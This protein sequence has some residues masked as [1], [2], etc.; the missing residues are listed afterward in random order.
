MTVA[1]L[2]DRIAAAY[3]GATP[4]AMATFKPVF[5]ARL[6][7]HEGP[8]LA[9]AANAV[10][11]AFKPTVRQ[12]FPIP[13]D[14]E[15]QLPARR[16]KMPGGPA[17]RLD[18]PA[19]NDRMRELLTQWRRRQGD[20]AS[21]GVPE[22]MR[23]L[24]HIASLH[25]SF[26]SWSDNPAAIV[27][28]V[29]ELMQARHRAISQQRRIEFGSLPPKSPEAF[30]AQVETIANRW[31]IA[32]RIEDWTAKTSERTE[33]RATEVGNPLSGQPTPPP[34]PQTPRTKAAALQA[35]ARFWRTQPNGAAMAD[36]CEAEAAAIV[37]D[38]E[39]RDEPVGEAA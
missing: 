2:L 36:Q 10:L 29:E 3:Q 8:A 33:W 24:E 18:I 9:E 27:L 4:E 28:T 22:V 35:R 37:G 1:E 6:R 15:T 14:F 31:G 39:H 12:P 34:L 7:Q 32:T 11:G 16:V 5:H 21:K 26:R 17:K 25:A 13:L 19:R 23:A 20:K 38:I 30:F